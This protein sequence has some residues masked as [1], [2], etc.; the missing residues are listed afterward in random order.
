MIRLCYGIPP[1][2][3]DPFCLLQVGLPLSFNRAAYVAMRSSYAVACLS[4]SIITAS[5]ALYFLSTLILA[6]SILSNCSISDLLLA[7]SLALASSY[8]AALPFY[9]PRNEW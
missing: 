9:A 5:S 4:T 8:I 2:C 3:C 1:L 6:N 7:I